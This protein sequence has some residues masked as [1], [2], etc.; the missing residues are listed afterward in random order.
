MD[1]RSITLYQDRSM[2]ESA[3]GLDRSSVS[4]IIKCS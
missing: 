3:T 4:D 2:N 1:P